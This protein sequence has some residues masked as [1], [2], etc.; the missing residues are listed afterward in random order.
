MARPNPGFRTPSFRSTTAFTLIELLTVIA[1]IGILAAIIIP[2]IGKVR[3]SA[4]RAQCA[5][6]L[7]Q[8]GLA[9][10]SWSADNKGRTLQGTRNATFIPGAADTWGANVLRYMQS[11][12]TLLTGQWPERFRCNAWATSEHANNLNTAPANIH[13][14][15]YGMVDPFG[16]GGSLNRGTMVSKADSTISTPT[17]FLYIGERAWNNIWM[18]RP[19]AAIV[20]HLSDPLDDGLKR[21]GTKSNY[22][23]LDGSV[24]A[25][26]L[27]EVV[28]AWNAT[29]DMLGPF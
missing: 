26:D 23:F 11:N 4:N 18:G 3:Q 14:V 12:N 13:F 24:R 2:T 1:I 17:R 22:L 9:A 7:R 29:V 15:G 5:S 16:L 20:T 28:T 6:N 10:K 19:E 27:P 8:I 25:M 21:H